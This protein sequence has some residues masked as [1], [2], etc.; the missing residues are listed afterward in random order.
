MIKPRKPFAA[1]LLS[2]FPGL[3]Q[4]YNGQ[5]TKGLIFVLIDLLFPVVFGLTG[6]LLN[7]SGLMIMVAV[8][9]VF[10]IY[11]MA[12]GYIV[13]KRL[14]EYELKAINK[15]YIYLLFALALIGIRV[16]LD[17]PTSTGIQTFKIPTPSMVPTLQPG[18]RVVAHLNSYKET[19]IEYGDIVV[20]NSPKGGIWTSRVIGLPLDSIE[21]VDGS[22]FVN[23]QLN[24]I[25]EGKEYNSQDEEVI[26][27]EEE[28]KN[29]KKI[30]TLRFKNNSFP[31]AR[32]MAK[33]LIPENEYFL[34]G[35]SRDNAFDSR[36]IGTIKEEDILGRV[37]YSYW[38]N[39]SDRINIDF[40]M[41]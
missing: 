29:K 11:R 12:D 37:I 36:F 14:K 5:L 32:T 9:I 18:D 31:D 19:K 30:K 26:E 23:G 2:L 17:A 1:L 4:I 38:G 40:K 3:G 28:L 39:S 8:G 16:F 20:F 6:L 33:R 10:L 15:G 7:M 27:F 41:K 21:I 22:V 34:M 35:D 24:E 25:R 13:A